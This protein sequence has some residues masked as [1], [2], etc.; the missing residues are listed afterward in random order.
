MI[1]PLPS[2]FKNPL[3]KR[4]VCRKAMTESHDLP[5]PRHLPGL[6]PSFCLWDKQKGWGLFLFICC[7]NKSQSQLD[8]LDLHPP[9]LDFRLHKEKTSQR[10][11]YRKWLLPAA[12]RQLSLKIKPSSQQV[13][14]KTFTS[15]LHCQESS[16]S[17]DI[18]L[19]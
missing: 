4:S 17:E 19:I 10:G 11:L 8:L 7:V 1:Y 9:E 18:H 13:E 15:P 12:L 16:W 3:L 14:L 6:D 2:I 5:A